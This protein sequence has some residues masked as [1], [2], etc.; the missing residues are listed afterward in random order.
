MHG[1]KIFISLPNAKS[2]DHSHVH[3]SC[4]NTE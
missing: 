3:F 4:T 1:L 2:L